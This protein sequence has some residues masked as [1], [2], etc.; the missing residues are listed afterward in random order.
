M[1]IKPEYTAIVT[2]TIEP[3]K[4][5]QIKFQGSWWTS[6]CEQNIKLKHGEIVQVVGRQG[7][8]LYVVPI[9]T[10]PNDSDLL[11]TPRSTPDYLYA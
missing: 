2:Q 10:I 7:L 5:G 3:G 6:R 8:T 4:S 9:P 11:N 1:R